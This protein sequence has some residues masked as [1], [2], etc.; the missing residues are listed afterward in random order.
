MAE[1]NRSLFAEMLL[2]LDSAA[3]A[4]LPFPFFYTYRSI[5]TGRIYTKYV[6]ME[7]DQEAG[8]SYKDVGRIL[9]IV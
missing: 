5:K 7:H 8:R 1:E 4:L 2:H 6:T 3:C 9:S